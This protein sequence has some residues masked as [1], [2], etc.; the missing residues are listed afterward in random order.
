MKKLAQRQHSSDWS[1]ELS[2]LISGASGGFLFGIPLLFYT[3]EVWF[4]GSQVS[5]P[6][7]LAILSL[8]D[9]YC[10]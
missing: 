2:D 9:D 10:F 1:K 8:T 4:V 6:L 5:P 3:M 7:L